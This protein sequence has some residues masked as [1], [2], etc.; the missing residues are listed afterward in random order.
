MR[1]M[2]NVVSPESLSVTR[3]YA[4]PASLSWNV[5]MIRSL[6]AVGS[7]ID[8]WVNEGGDSSSVSIVPMPVLIVCTF[9]GPA[10]SVSSNIIL[11][12]L[13]PMPS[14]SSSSAKQYMYG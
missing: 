6:N 13:L 3:Q 7:S 9:E 11:F 4:V 1:L 14:V 8:S 12:G 2:R 10:F 5:T